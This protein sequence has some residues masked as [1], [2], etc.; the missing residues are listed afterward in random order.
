MN[1][2]VHEVFFL[3]FELLLLSL[4]HCFCSALAILHPPQLI[5]LNMHL[6]S[7]GFVQGQFLTE[8]ESFQAVYEISPPL[9]LSQIML[10]TIPTSTIFVVMFSL[11]SLVPPPASC[12]YLEHL[13]LLYELTRRK[14]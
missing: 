7:P 11:E 10:V 3:H 4:I 13:S 12:T 5:S 6:F 14:F 9:K 8:S 2:F 1:L